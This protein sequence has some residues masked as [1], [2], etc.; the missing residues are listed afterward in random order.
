M[1]VNES[2]GLTKGTLVYWRGIPLTAAL[3]PK[4]VGMQ[5]QSPG[6]MGRWPPC[7]TGTC[8]TFSERRQRRILCKGSRNIAGSNLI[9]VFSQR[10]KI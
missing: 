7:T 10:R 3:S 4:Q 6:I 8:V 1:K 9:L 5:L 2:K